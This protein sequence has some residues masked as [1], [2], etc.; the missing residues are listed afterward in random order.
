MNYD[1]TAEIQHPF[2][3]YD[4]DQLRSHLTKLMGHK[5]D[6][7]KLWYACK[8]NPCAAILNCL[9]SLGYSFDVASEGEFH[10][11][12]RNSIEADNILATGPAK[13]PELIASYL[14]KGMRTFVAESPNQ[15]QWLEEQAHQR[16]LRLTVLLRIQGEWDS[17]EKSV[18]GGSDIT[19]FGM[20]VSDWERVFPTIFDHLEIK[21]FHIFQWG[22]QLELNRLKTIWSECASLCLEASKKLSLPFKIL[23]I[24]GG[25]GIPYDGSKQHFPVKEMF[26]FLDGLTKEFSLDQI[27]MELGRFAVGECGR[28]FTRVIDMKQV[29]GKDLIVLESG[30]N[31]LARPALVD[32]SFPLKNFS[33]EEGEPKIFQVHGPL[34]TGLDKL[35]SF[36]LP[37]NTAVGD[38]LVFD[39]VGAYGFT[40]SMPFFLGH[41]LPAEAIVSEGDFQVVRPPLPASTYLDAF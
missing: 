34:C 14:E 9:N 20:S 27:W 25:I 31:Q 12:I 23:D 35:G 32:Q 29:R 5:P 39:N 8:A 16:D 19:P 41:H 17:E 38:W 7:V 3:L 13:S 11:L 24:G 30:I 26:S 1:F 28:F 36:E 22:N 2:F 10:Q 21:G 40:E 33:K 15:L 18:L 4:I 6:S 37:E